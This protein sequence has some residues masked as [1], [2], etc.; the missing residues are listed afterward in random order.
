[1]KKWIALLLLLVLLTGCAAPAPEAPE[2]TPPSSSTVPSTGPS[3]TEPSVTEPPA[4][5]PPITEPPATQPPAT[6]PPATKPPATQPPATKPPV[7]EPPFRGSFSVHFIDVGQADCALLECNGEYALIDGGN[8]D[9]TELVKDYLEEQ[10]VD[11]LSLVVGTHHHEDHIGGLPGVLNTY[12]TDTVWS[13][14]ATFYNGYVNAFLLSA[15][16]QSQL[17]YPTPGTTYTLGGATLT[18]LGPVRSGYDDV[19]DDSLVIMAQ[20]GT[21][22][23]LFTGDMEQIA[24]TDLLDSG[25]D[26]KAD[27][28]KVGH[29]GSYSSTSYRFLRE[30]APTYA[31]ISA[32]SGNEYGHPHDSTLSKL[33]NADVIIYRT[34]QMCSIVATSDGT[35]IKF[36]WENIY[37]KPWKPAA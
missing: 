9:D 2:A 14:P 11:E 4:T 37:A 17:V 35:D 28:L 20:Y 32:G 3:A 29:H 22:R 16:N 6:Q 5:Q 33:K 26:L 24:E 18:L 34:D 13:T 30:V 23:F 8:T 19:N 1:M 36:S 10:G 25:A 7:V 15:Q 21:T 27:V 12:P 31:V